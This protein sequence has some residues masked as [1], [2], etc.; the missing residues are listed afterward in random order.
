MG[1]FITLTELAL[2]LIICLPVWA[3][4]KTIIDTITNKIK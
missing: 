1:Q 4:I 3:L 2:I